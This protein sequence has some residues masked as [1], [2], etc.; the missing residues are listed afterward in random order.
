M[1]VLDFLK[2]FG[3]SV[4]SNNPATMLVDTGANIADLGIATAGYV[5]NKLG[6]LSA[7]QMP[8][9]L[10]RKKIPGSSE[11]IN[12]R[13]GVNDSTASTVGQLGGMFVQPAKAAKFIGKADKIF[14]ADLATKR[15][16]EAKKLIAG[17]MSKEDAWRK[18]GVTEFG[19]GNWVT[20]VSSQGATLKRPPSAFAVGKQYTL[21]EVLHHPGLEAIADKK[22]LKQLKSTK[23]E[24]YPPEHRAMNGA[25]GGHIVSSKGEPSVIRVA[26]DE[27]DPKGVANALS[28]LLHESQ[29]NL[30]SRT[31]GWKG[32]QAAAYSSEIGSAVLAENNRVRRQMA[33]AEL[34]HKNKGNLAKAEEQFAKR[35]PDSE[36]W[37]EDEWIQLRLAAR[38][39]ADNVDL[40]TI[41]QFKE[42][43]QANVN[44]VM[45]YKKFAWEKGVGAGQRLE[46]EQVKY[47]KQADEAAARAVQSRVR[48][49]QREIYE[50]PFWTDGW[51][52]A[53]TDKGTKALGV[54]Y[55]DLEFNPRKLGDIQL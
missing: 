28:T 2:G 24:F 17:G 34:V 32:G 42:Q 20:E 50:N 5:G 21:D 55:A 3:A 10:D 38:D 29:H 53:V 49:N 36:T 43:A 47:Y 44:K 7:G 8:E 48:L 16:E 13:V 37:S 39:I 1:N 14:G 12:E 33:L 40:D 19:P 30:S 6:M 15:I 45:D 11:W 31:G 18:T 52:D 27:D 41:K 26:Y 51:M 46:P 35:F 22:L 4:A 9:T 23:I 54:G 25:T